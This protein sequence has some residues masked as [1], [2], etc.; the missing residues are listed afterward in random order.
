MSFQPAPLTRLQVKQ[1]LTNELMLDLLPQKTH[2]LVISVPGRSDSPP[3]S[4]NVPRSR[5]LGTYDE[6]YYIVVYFDLSYDYHRW[7]CVSHDT[8]LFYNGDEVPIWSVP[9]RL[10]QEED[11]ISKPIGFKLYQI[12]VAELQFDFSPELI[13]EALQMRL[14]LYKFFGQNRAF[15]DA[16]P[17]TDKQLANAGVGENPKALDTFIYW[18]IAHSIEK[19][20][21][22]KEVFVVC[23]AQLLIFKLLLRPD[24]ST[25]VCE[26]LQLERSALSIACAM[27]PKF[28]RKM[29]STFAAIP[30]PAFQNP[31]LRACM[32]EFLEEAIRIANV[33]T[34]DA[35][36]QE[37]IEGIKQQPPR[38]APPKAK[39][40]MNIEDIRS[41]APE[42]MK[43]LI[44]KSFGTAKQQ[45]Q[46]TLLD[47]RMLTHALLESRLDSEEVNLHMRPKVT[48]EYEAES[49]LMSLKDITQS[50]RDVERERWTF[51]NDSIGGDEEM[52]QTCFSFMNYAMCPHMDPVPPN[53]H[54]LSKELKR[55]RHKE[56]YVKAKKA[57]HAHLQAIWNKRSTAGQSKG[58]K[59]KYAWTTTPYTFMQV[60][61]RGEAFNT[62]KKPDPNRPA[63][64]AVK[65]KR[66]TSSSKKK[67]PKKE[68]AAAAAASDG[69]EEEEEEEANENV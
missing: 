30:V 21:T 13:A 10:C 52:H 61:F 16:H 28:H 7:E 32:K 51:T 67:K 54:L 45:A 44:C 31:A 59:V 8:L 36:A 23:E 43:R 39:D 5:F 47:R 15:Q 27:A 35:E 58:E 22:A 17:L 63:K 24:L 11:A 40:K 12:G 26:I 69:D 46:T 62:D 64:P 34:D 41:C 57:C 66:H 33:V 6:W 42:C 53:Q 48:I 1:K 20:P 9:N 50:I 14:T 37:D 65:R 38:I 25:R 2:L 3:Q 19:V 49:P 56:R 18:F 4:L 60:A 55:Q 29:Q 68:E